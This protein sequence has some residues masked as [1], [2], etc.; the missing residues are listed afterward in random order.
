VSIS[1]RLW[2]SQQLAKLRDARERFIFQGGS[3]YA[4]QLAHHLSVAEQQLIAQ[5]ESRT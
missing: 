4:L 1:Q 2:L 3:Q 5:S